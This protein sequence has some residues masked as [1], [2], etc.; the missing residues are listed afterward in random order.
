MQKIYAK[1]LWIYKKKHWASFIIIIL[2]YNDANGII[3]DIEI[4]SNHVDIGV[5]LRILARIMCDNEKLDAAEELLNRILSIYHKLGQEHPLLAE[6]Y[7]D[8]ARLYFDKGNFNE[9]HHYY[10]KALQLAVSD[11]LKDFNIELFKGKNLWKPA[12]NRW[13]YLSFPC[14]FVHEHEKYCRWN[15]LSPN[16]DKDHGGSICQSAIASRHCM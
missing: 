9:A 15:Q 13:Q 8:I 7:T 6:L 4:G 1:R 2:C 10:Q 11:P 3:Y 14:K 16:W 12:R 5:T